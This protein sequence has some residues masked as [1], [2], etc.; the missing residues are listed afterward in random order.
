MIEQ[1]INLYQERFHEKRL[2]LSA[3]QTATAL[4][5]LLALIAGAS[6]LMQSELQ[7]AERRGQQLKAERD[8]VTAELTTANLEL[9]Q[10]LEDTRLDRE[11]ESTAR[12]ISARKKV[13]A[14]VD[15][16]RFGSGQ[17]FSDY[18]VALS[19]LHIEDIW[20]SRIR[21]GENFIQLKGSS[22]DAGR[23]PAY[24]DSFSDEAVFQ[25]NRFDLFELKRDP[26]NDWK[27]DFEIATRETVDG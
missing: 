18:L 16:N 15:A 8:L 20:L 12:Q 27:V 1:Q 21:L 23:V 17:G 2:W 7:Q 4:A 10:L 5:V 3:A 24:F 22:L 9:R 25:G 6:F 19:R 11:I 14:F 26:D 13:L